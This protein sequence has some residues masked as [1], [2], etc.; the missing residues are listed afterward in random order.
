MTTT[1]SLTERLQADTS[2]AP[3]VNTRALIVIIG[4]AALGLIGL[5]LI[6]RR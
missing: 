2:P 5:L 1:P 6:S 3:K 4:L